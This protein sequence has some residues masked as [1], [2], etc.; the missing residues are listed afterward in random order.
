MTASAWPTL[1]A[2]FYAIL[3]PDD[4]AQMSYWRVQTGRGT[5]FGPWPKPRVPLGFG[6]IDSALRRAALAADAIAADVDG[7]RARFAVFAI[8]CGC[9]GK[10]LRTPQ[11][12]V[13]GIGP[14]CRRGLPASY[15]EAT[16]A[17][18][19]RAHAA[20]IETAK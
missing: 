11:S 3:D 20:H 10:T 9:C 7:A 14:E 15:L 18:V 8:R 19:A 5:S 17:A 16:A 12:K 4:P 13:A 2:G 1:P 6:D